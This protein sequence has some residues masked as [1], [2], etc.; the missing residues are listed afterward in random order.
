MFEGQGK[1]KKKTGAKRETEESREWET[2]GTWLWKGLR[3]E[4]CLEVLALERK[5]TTLSET[6]KIRG[7]LQF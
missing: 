1:K 4:T 6:R 5:S 7:E 2:P 3:M